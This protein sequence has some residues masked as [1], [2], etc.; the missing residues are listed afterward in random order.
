MYSHPPHR[1]LQPYTLGKGTLKLEI[2]LLPRSQQELTVRPSFLPCASVPVTV[3]WGTHPETL[4]KTNTDNLEMLAGMG[5][6]ETCRVPEQ[7]VSRP[8]P[9]NPSGFRMGTVA[10][11]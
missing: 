4:R 2:L 7:P 9:A 1:K 10:V 5:Q 6:C 3:E 8:W 11:I